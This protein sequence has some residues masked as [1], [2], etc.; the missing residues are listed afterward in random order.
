[1]FFVDAF[2]ACNLTARQECGGA[3]AIENAPRRIRKEIK[4]P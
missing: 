4:G 1:M 3:H 2:G